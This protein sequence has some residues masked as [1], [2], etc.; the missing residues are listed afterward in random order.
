MKFTQ[1]HRK[2]IHFEMRNHQFT[3]ED[4]EYVKRRG[5]INII[6]S[7][8][9]QCF[10]YF[11]K[12]ETSIDPATQHW[13]ETEHFLVSFNSQKEF[14]SSTWVNV[15]VDFSQWLKSIARRGE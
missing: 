9:K 14:E 5:R 7:E 12:K 4:F 15:I 2:S 10:T 11:R 6:H 3:P 1:A 13:V 8:S